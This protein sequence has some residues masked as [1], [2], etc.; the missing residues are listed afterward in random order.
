M[1]LKNCVKLVPSFCSLE[2]HYLPEKKVEDNSELGNYWFIS[3]LSLIS[4]HC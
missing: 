3:L 2:C 4:G 1:C